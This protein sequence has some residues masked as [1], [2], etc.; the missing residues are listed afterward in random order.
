[1]VA[2]VYHEK[3]LLLI[4]AMG[5]YTTQ[6]FCAGSCRHILPE[7]PVDNQYLEEEVVESELE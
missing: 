3:D 4:L 7:Q 1:M 2:L 6:T 5:L